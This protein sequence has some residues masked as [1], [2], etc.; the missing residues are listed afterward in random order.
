MQLTPSPSESES[1]KRFHWSIFY[2]QLMMFLYS[3]GGTIG[4]FFLY[5]QSLPAIA[6]WSSIAIL[7]ASMTGVYGLYKRALYGYLIGIVFNIWYLTKNVFD[8]ISREEDAGKLAIGDGF[9][10][11]V[12]QGELAGAVSAE[13]YTPMILVGLF[14]L[15]LLH[16]I[17]SKNI[18]SEFF[19]KNI[20][21]VSE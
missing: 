5:S 13:L 2:T 12:N 11:P 9:L 10:D 15:S 17:L 8:F 19:G 21:V 1:I 16:F 4:V 7:I 3:V 20:N 18:K 6:H 14:S